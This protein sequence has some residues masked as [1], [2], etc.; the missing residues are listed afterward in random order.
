MM[1]ITLLKKSVKYVL[2][3]FLFLFISCKVGPKSNNNSG[4]PSGNS[5]K[6]VTSFFLEGGQSQYYVKPL[7]YDAA[8]SKTILMDFVFKTKSDSIDTGL[9]YLSL[10][11][12]DKLT[13]NDLKEVKIGTVSLKTKNQI[14]T[15]FKKGKYEVRLSLPLSAEEFRKIQPDS[16]IELLLFD[17][18]N[19][20]LPSQKTKKV[21][22]YV[23]KNVVLQ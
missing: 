4:V 16:Q 5:S 2:F 19:I 21:L 10:F 6:Y 12:V 11:Q 17:E 7:K 22:D 13:F 8:N 18:I 23:F 1:K 9:I 15:E 3:S 20:F 14:Y